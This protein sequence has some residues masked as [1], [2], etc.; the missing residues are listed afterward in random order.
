MESFWSRAAFEDGEEENTLSIVSQGDLIISMSPQ[1]SLS[2]VHS[3][4]RVGLT[5]S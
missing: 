2:S 5:R 4:S 1:N 3:A